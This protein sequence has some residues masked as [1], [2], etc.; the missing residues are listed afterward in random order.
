MISA[1]DE[2]ATTTLLA[3]LNLAIDEEWSR[4]VRLLCRELQLSCQV[5]CARV[6]AHFPF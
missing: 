6:S 1:E 5:A 4:H 3:L 2:E